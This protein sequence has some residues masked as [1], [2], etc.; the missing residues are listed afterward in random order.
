MRWIPVALDLHAA[1]GPVEVGQV[2]RGE[3]EV[4]G[5]EVLVQ[6]LEA[7]GSGDG[8]DPGPLREQPGQRD[9][10]GGGLLALGKG[11]DEVDEGE[12]RLQGLAFESGQGGA[13]VALT[14]LGGGGDLTGQEATPERTTS[15]SWSNSSSV[16]PR[17]SSVG[18]LTRTSRSG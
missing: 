11:S 18:V 9:L 10:A 5:P 4:R 17:S 12:V 1:G 14:E 15:A 16:A 7:P 3:L 6:A 2:L 8:G 13:D